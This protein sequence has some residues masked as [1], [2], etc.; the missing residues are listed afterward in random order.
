MNATLICTVNHLVALFI[1]LC[2]V[3]EDPVNRDAMGNIVNELE[4]SSL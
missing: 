1:P 3:E 4:Q 2:T